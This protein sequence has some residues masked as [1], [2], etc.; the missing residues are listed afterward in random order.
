LVKANTSKLGNAK[1]DATIN[2]KIKVGCDP[3]TKRGSAL[4]V[5]KALA[6]S[7]IQ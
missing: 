5:L 1:K 3:C 2:G 4:V 7:F 6:V